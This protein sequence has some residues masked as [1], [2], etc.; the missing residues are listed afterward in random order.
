MRTK[1]IKLIYPLSSH[2]WT[3]HFST[4]ILPLY[5]YPKVWPWLSQELVY[6]EN[7]QSYQTLLHLTHLDERV[8]TASVWTKAKLLKKSPSSA[9]TQKGV[10]ANHSHCAAV[11]WR[12]H[13]P[14][15]QYSLKASVQHFCHGSKTPQTATQIHYTPIWPQSCWGCAQGSLSYTYC[16]PA[17]LRRCYQDILLHK[18]W[19]LQKTPRHLNVSQ[20]EEVWNSRKAPRQ[21][22]KGG[23]TPL[24]LGL[25]LENSRSTYTLQQWRGAIR[26]LGSGFAQHRVYKQKKC[27]RTALN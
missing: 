2:F 18:F 27:V 9:Q 22:A 25:T 1:R 21:Q 10:V 26:E 17:S 16:L 4:N 6:I 11:P 3:Q 5:L 14:R 23:V 24:R 12:P 7:K 13:M 19:Q 8:N 15:S 20:S